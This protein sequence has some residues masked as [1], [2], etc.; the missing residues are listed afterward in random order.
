[1]R[2]RCSNHKQIGIDILDD[3]DCKS[4]AK[5]IAITNKNVL[6]DNLLLIIIAV[7]IVTTAIVT[8]SV[9]TY[10]C[11]ELQICIFGQCWIRLCHSAI[12]ESIIS[13]YI[14]FS[15][16]NPIDRWHYKLLLLK[17]PNDVSLK[18]INM[19]FYASCAYLSMTSYLNSALHGLASFSK[20]ILLPSS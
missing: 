17:K 13:C 4:L 19:K 2:I 8:V 15:T 5:T 20:P 18:Q 11:K 7:S 14:A 1:M 10:Y 6:I 3:S 16:K 12:I 9:S